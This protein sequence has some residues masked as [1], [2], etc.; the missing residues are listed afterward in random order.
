METVNTSNK[1][2]IHFNLFIENFDKVKNFEFFFPHNNSSV[3]FK[4]INKKI[5]I[6]I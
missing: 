2:R 3:I 5:K 4:S 1:L 6:N